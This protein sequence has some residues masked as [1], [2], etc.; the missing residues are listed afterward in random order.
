MYKNVNFRTDMADE[1]IDQYK[2]VNNLTELDGVEVISKKE[3]DISV[4]SVNVLN[5]NGERALQ[6]KIGSYI[7]IET[8][9][10]KYLDDEEENLLINSVSNEIKEL[11][12]KL[13][14]KENA[15]VLVV[16]LGNESITPD[17]IGPKVIKNVSITR[18][19]L[20]YA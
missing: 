11:V 5:E 17:S 9:D 1:R 18:H 10:I 8:S 14:N 19:L 20:N 15:S 12:T 6:K 7:T 3:K 2:K 16:G 13:T 4:T